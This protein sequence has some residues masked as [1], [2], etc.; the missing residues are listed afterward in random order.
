MID[1]SSACAPGELWMLFEGDYAPC[2]QGGQGRFV[3]CT[4]TDNQ[5]CV[6]A[7]DHRRLQQTGHHHRL[8]QIAISTERQIL[9]D[10]GDYPKML[11]N[12]ALAPDSREGAEYSPVYNFVRPE[13][14]F[15]HVGPG[16]RPEFGHRIKPANQLPILYRYGA[17]STTNRTDIRSARQPLDR[18]FRSEPGK[19]LLSR[20]P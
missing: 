13:L 11:R 12:E 5:D 19:Q 16:R 4:G 17:A 15:D 3:S 7:L 1:E 9:V 18:L 8:H 14:A 20:Q 6:S 2:Q 10:V